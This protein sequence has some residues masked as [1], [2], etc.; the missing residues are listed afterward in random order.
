MYD[1]GLIYLKMV[2]GFWFFKIIRD[3][4]STMFALRVLFGWF[5]IVV[6]NFLKI[7]RV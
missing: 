4:I 3:V 7:Y 2:F 6:F 1:V 5:C